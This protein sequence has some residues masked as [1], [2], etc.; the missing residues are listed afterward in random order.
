VK[1]RDFQRL[2]TDSIDNARA[3]REILKVA[4]ESLY[5]GPHRR[6]FQ[7]I[8]RFQVQHELHRGCVMRIP[9]SGSNSCHKVISLIDGR[10]T[11]VR[12]MIRRASEPSSVSAYPIRI[13]IRV[14]VRNALRGLNGNKFYSRGPHGIPINHTLVLFLRGRENSE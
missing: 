11:G 13:E 1:T 12:E 7:T 8:C 14:S 3:P 2:T 5:P 9:S 4:H 10:Y 6:G